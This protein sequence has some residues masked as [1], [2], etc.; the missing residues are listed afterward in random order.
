MTNTNDMWRVYHYDTNEL[1]C[2]CPTA[3]LADLMDSYVS[4][5]SAK[6]AFIGNPG[7]SLE[8]TLSRLEIEHVKFSAP[9]GQ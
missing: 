6:E 2:Y 8:E 7:E 9:S 5:N 4:A 3:E 1:L